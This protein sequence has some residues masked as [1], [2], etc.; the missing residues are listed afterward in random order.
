MSGEAQPAGN[1][2][3]DG[4]RERFRDHVGDS[5]RYG[6]LLLLILVSLVVSVSA[7]DTD[8]ARMAIV[9]LQGVTLLVALWTSGARRPVLRLAL[10]VVTIAIAASA[11]ALLGGDE[12]LS[13]VLTRLDNAFLVLLAPVVIARTVAREVIARR[14]VTLQEVL[15]VVC[16]YLL[17]GMFFGFAYGTIGAID[18]G[19][20]FAQKAAEDASDFTYFSF[21][22]LTTVGYGDL[23]A[24]ADVGR[25]FAI[26]EA[27]TGQ[28][29]LVTVIA[30]FVSNLG[31]R[32]ARPA[33]G[34][35]AAE[36]ESDA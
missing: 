19:P 3:Q 7:E 15:G 32:A 9:V 13:L 33:P 34:P 12:R 16:I 36:P 17:V 28:L 25:A 35:R 6:L 24:A 31:R 20:F 22:T 21:V 29:Y 30:V 8:A 11:A 5:E 4:L 23:T 18:D 10:A 14:A 27:L 2:A 1:G 26:I